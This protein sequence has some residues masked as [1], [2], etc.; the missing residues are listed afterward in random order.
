MS[1]RGGRERKVEYRERDNVMGG[2][3]GG[4][5]VAGTQ[6]QRER[7]KDRKGERERRTQSGK[8]DETR[9]AVEESGVSQSMQW[10][11][12]GNSPK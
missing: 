7:Q 5:R 10:S 1:K 9:S 2:R 8:K 3:V 6:A 4:G 12:A 11:T